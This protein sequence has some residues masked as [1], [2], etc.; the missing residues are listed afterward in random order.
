MTVL[1]P[2]K[3]NIQGVKIS[4]KIAGSN[5]PRRLVRE[6]NFTTQLGSN[7]GEEIEYQFI[8]TGITFEDLKN[9]EPGALDAFLHCLE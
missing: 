7:I 5:D 8:D 3:T 9:E 6:I 4:R 2:P 1:K